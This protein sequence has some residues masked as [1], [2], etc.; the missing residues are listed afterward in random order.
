MATTK[1]IVETHP[2]TSDR[3]RDFSVLM[4]GRFDTRRCWCMWPRRETDYK[5]WSAESNRRAIKRAVDTAPAPPGVLAYVD[6]EPAGWCAVAPREEY[7]KLGR[8]R[9][10]APLDDGPVWSVVCFLVLRSQRGK[11]VSRVLLEAAVDLAAE[12]GATI[13]EGYPVE[14]T[15]NVFRGVTSVFKEAGFK[16]VG[17]RKANRPVMRYQIRGRRRGI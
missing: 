16:E 17:R 2:L 8:D 10:T 12:H 5:K 14:G 1:P 3:W 4:N 6:G 15:R 9:A 11:G 13:V 7:P